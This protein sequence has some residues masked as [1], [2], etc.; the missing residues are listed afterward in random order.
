MSYNKPIFEGVP[1]HNTNKS[2]FDLSH[3]YKT[4]IIPGYL[5]PVLTMETMPGDEFDINSE[6][7]FRFAPLYF[8]IMQKMTMRADYFFIPNRILWIYQSEANKGWTR[9]ISQYEDTTHPYFDANLEYSNGSFPLHVLGYMGLPL[10]INQAGI[11]TEI[12]NL[13]ALPLNAYLKIWDEYYRNPQLE[14]ER[15]FP[16]TD[17]D[18]TTAFNTAF[19]VISNT[20]LCL[21]S[22]WEMDYFTG[23]L[24]TPQLG[25]AVKMPL[26]TNEGLAP[27]RAP[28]NW[29]NL[30]TGANAESGE[31]KYDS[32]Q[33]RSEDVTAEPIGLDIESTAPS[34]REL[35]LAEVLQSYYERILK[36]GTRYRD[37]IKGFFGNDPEPYVIDMPVLIGSKFGRV[38]ISDVMVQ[39]DYSWP[40][41]Y[42]TS[43]QAGDYRGHANL[44]T[45]DDGRMRYFCREHGWLMCI[46]QVNPNTNYGLGIERFW[47]RQVQT[48]YPL[49]M[50]SSIGD[51]EILREELMYNP[52]IAEA[53]LN[54]NTF[55][56][57]PRFSEMRYKNNMYTA[58]LAF[59]TGK[60]EHLGRIFDF[61]VV[62]NIEIDANFLTANPK[63][64][65]EGG[66]RITDAFRVL[67]LASYSQS[68]AEGIIYCHIYHDINVNRNLPFYSTPDLT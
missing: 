9:W 11:S 36:I 55:G 66:T 49:D 2:R 61:E 20:Y 6:F 22:K 21:P 30:D 56:Y 46:L 12:E 59:N 38:Q 43:T 58:H 15:W 40:I 47:R 37:F 17:G 67:P 45:G 31:V 29:I 28:S 63:D 5:F 8:P 34:I 16:L 50:F 62:P 57:I 39:A 10:Q 13:N 23:A 7:L 18:N 33:S 32:A 25:D 26:V 65:G 19:G 42:D 52:K 48:D 53:A 60:S 41:N 3:E 1:K 44:Y 64:A 4:Q 35:R 27:L 14:E 68:P 51:Q 24:P 54:Q